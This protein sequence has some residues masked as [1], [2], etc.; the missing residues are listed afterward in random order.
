MSTFILYKYLSHLYLKKVGIMLILSYRI[1]IVITASY[2]CLIGY[3]I[4]PSYVYEDAKSRQTMNVVE[5]I[6]LMNRR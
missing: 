2:F 4:P 6:D 5:V 3:R 1:M